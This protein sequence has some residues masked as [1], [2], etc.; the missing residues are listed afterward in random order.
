SQ[1][2]ERCPATMV[3]G[4]RSAAHVIVMRRQLGES[5]SVAVAAQPLAGARHPL[6]AVDQRDPAV[7]ALDKEPDRLE[8]APVVVHYD[9]A[10]AGTA[11]I[12]VHEDDRQLPAPPQVDD[13]GWDGGA[14]G[15]DK[16]VDVSPA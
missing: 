13:L 2:V 1:K 12:P 9:P 8:R 6:R 16:T 14:G 5:E 15:Q 4:E 10:E 3:E 11:A 7:T